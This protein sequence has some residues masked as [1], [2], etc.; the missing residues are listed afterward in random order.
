MAWML[1]LRNSL[2]LSLDENT[3]IVIRAQRCARVGLKV[4]LDILKVKGVVRTTSSHRL[5]VLHP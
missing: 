3:A 5:A 1:V 4:D 2:D